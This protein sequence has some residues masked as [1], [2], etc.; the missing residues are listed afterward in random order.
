MIRKLKIDDLVLDPR[1]Q[2]RAGCNEEAI[3]EYAEA[4]KDG[5]EFPP[6]TVVSVDGA[7]Y[8]VD[9]WHRVKAH[10]DADLEEIDATVQEGAWSTAIAWAAAANAAHGLRRTP[11][12]KRRAVRM[13]L[14]DEDLCRKSSR[15]LGGIAKASHTFV[16]KMRKRY[17]VKVGEVLTADRI[18]EVDGEMR[19]EWKALFD[20]TPEYGRAEVERVRVAPGPV[21]LAM[22][23]GYGQHIVDA[24]AIRAKELA[25][26]GFDEV[27]WDVQ[28][29]GLAD[30]EEPTPAQVA[31]VLDCEDDIV[32]MLRCR[33]LPD[34]DRLDLYRQ[35]KD[36]RRLP[37][38]DWAS[39]VAELVKR[40][41]NRPRMHAAALARE[42]QVR[43]AQEERQA[44]DPWRKVRAISDA[45]DDPKRQTEL[46]AEIPENMLAQVRA[47]DLHPSVRDG[48]YQV[49]RC[50][51]LGPTKCANP[52]CVGGWVPPQ[53]YDVCVV[54]S[55]HPERFREHAK[56]SAIQTLALVEG[57]GY[58]VRAGGATVDAAALQ[59]LGAFEAAH[60]DGAIDSWLKKA[61]AAV[62]DAVRAW[63][64]RG[65]PT[66]VIDPDEDLDEDE[67]PDEDLDEDED[68][69]RVCGC[70][71]MEACED[72][73]GNTCSWVE[74]PEGG[75]LCSACAEDAGAEAAK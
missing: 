9:G 44:K 16:D 17:G 33:D 73:D 24:K 20:R 13:C 28:V 45:K 72:D 25:T 31:A 37:K 36:L 55:Q 5:K 75:M 41:A 70:T 74:D 67:D 34:E 39:D 71:E 12:D 61:P 29:E 38:I 22:L 63:L 50:G 56:K 53:D 15:E 10:E 7:L 54:C 2:A 3:G 58:A 1:L 14:A 46:L 32:E 69:C 27:S 49:L 21:E 40:W 64:D 60:A 11:D 19:P 59:L 4:L 43:A 26:T 18:D 52:L 68:A 47:S 23:E 30:D 35:L 51:G 65:E 42:E 62:K 8:V 48:A 57:G 66:V 6:I